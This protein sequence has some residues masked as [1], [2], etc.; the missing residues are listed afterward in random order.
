MVPIGI[1]PGDQLCQGHAALVGDFLQAVPE[2]VFKADAGLV[3]CNN[4]RTFG[5]TL[6]PPRMTIGIVMASPRPNCDPA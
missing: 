2:Q 3:P 4:N 6:S 5:N 1:D